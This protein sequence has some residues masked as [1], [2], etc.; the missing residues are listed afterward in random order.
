MLKLNASF[1]PDFNILTW[2]QLHFLDFLLMNDNEPS[3]NDQKRSIYLIWCPLG[4]LLLNDKTNLKVHYI[5]K[6]K[7]ARLVWPWT[8]ADLNYLVLGTFLPKVPWSW[9]SLWRSMKVLHFHFVRIG[10]VLVWGVLI[11]KPSVNR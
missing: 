9:R 11:V 5:T 10:S 3:K 6:L 4:R 7:K 1:E 8:T 2:H